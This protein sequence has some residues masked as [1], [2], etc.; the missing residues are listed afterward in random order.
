MEESKA[1]ILV[2]IA[3][4]GLG[5][6]V[7]SATELFGGCTAWHSEGGWKDPDTGKLMMEPGITV[8]IIGGWYAVAKWAIRECEL[9][10]EKCAYQRQGDRIAFPGPG[11]DLARL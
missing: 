7:Q 6:V 8:E 9:T 10:G 3:N 11:M 5:A 1:P 4:H 2:T